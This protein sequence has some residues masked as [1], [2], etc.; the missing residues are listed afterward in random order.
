[1]VVVIR[2]TGK[3]NIGIYFFSFLIN[4]IKK[5]KIKWNHSRDVRTFSIMQINMLILA[6]TQ[7]YKRT[8]F[9]GLY[10]LF[11]GQ[12]CQLVVLRARIEDDA[13]RFQ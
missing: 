10:A 8:S 12:F 9:N 6:S 13:T 2:G 1:M 5:I 11:D 3:T 7:H 4:Y